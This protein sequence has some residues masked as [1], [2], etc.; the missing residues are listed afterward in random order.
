LKTLLTK[1]CWILLLSS[2]F[3]SCATYYQINSEFNQN[4]E[5]GNIDAAKKVLSQNKKAIRKRTQ[6][7]YYANSGVLH[8]MKGDHEKSN[9]AFEK[10]YVFGEDYQKNYINEAA[11]FLVNPN[12][13][14]YQGEDHEQL[15]LLYYKALNYLKLQDYESALVECRRLNNRLN[16]LSDKYK[17]DKKYKRDAFV[18]NLMG[19]IY[20]ASG[21]INNAFVAYRN[22]YNIY[23][24]EYVKM[25]GVDVP[26]QLKKDLLRAAHLNGY[27]SD[28]DF[29]EKKFDMRHTDAAK[30]ELVFFWHNGLGPVKDE[31]SVNF[32]TVP[33]SGGMMTFANEDFGL[34]FNFPISDANQKSQ[35][36]DLRI[37]RVAFPRYQ[38]RKPFYSK[39][40]LETHDD[41]VNL[42]LAE[43]INAIAFK[44]LEERMLLE[45]SKG[46]MRAAMKKAVELSVRGDQ[47]NSGELTKEEQQEQAIREGLSMVVGLFNAVTEKADTR[48]WQTIPHSIYYSRVPMKVGS[49]QV[50]LKTSQNGGQHVSQTF[51]F[52]VSKGQTIFHS[53]QS[54]EYTR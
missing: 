4:F 26:D 43:D 45:M 18:H 50:T 25:F 31:W 46:L 34:N 10:A 9:Q 20:E 12:T 30:Q 40:V 13:I 38:E 47:S 52:D 22:A 48:N 2:S 3:F 6:F 16:E 29:F 49:N 23:E 24:E 8:S 53:Y 11:S 37:F 21:D 1:L 15:L 44:T 5:A 28:L 19:I 33:G 51:E 54:L 17:S 42:E 32:T 7:L 27:N 41:R 39:A 14:A 35:L 36:T